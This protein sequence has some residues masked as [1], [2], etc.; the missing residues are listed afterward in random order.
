MSLHHH[1][2]QC[3]R[4]VGSLH[5]SLLTIV[6]RVLESGPGEGRGQAGL[7]PPWGGRPV[8][9]QLAKGPLCRLCVGLPLRVV[10]P[11]RV[12]QPVQL[13]R[14][15]RAAGRR[16]RGG[17]PVIRS[18]CPSW[19]RPCD[20]RSERWCRPR[21]PGVAAGR[22]CRLLWPCRGDCASGAVKGTGVSPYR[23]AAEPVPGGGAAGEERPGNRRAVSRGRRPGPAGLVPGAGC[24]GPGAGGR[25]PDAGCRMRMPRAA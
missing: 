16:G 14:P 6:S 7:A 3:E 11:V 5:W 21:R 19:P 17:R 13:G 8:D 24:R 1:P 12:G 10:S 4:K 9:P 23:A 2:A 15:G 20:A 18:P 22:C 25:V